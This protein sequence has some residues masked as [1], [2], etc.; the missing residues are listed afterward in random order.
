MV[1]STSGMKRLGTDRLRE[2]L[3]PGEDVRLVAPLPVHQDAVDIR[4]RD[5]ANT[6]RMEV[7][8]NP[9]APHTVY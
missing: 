2:D 4:G 9:G 1:G 7:A 8:P 6:A 3:L 5:L